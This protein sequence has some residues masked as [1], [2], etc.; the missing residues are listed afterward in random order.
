MQDYIKGEIL[1]ISPHEIRRNKLLNFKAKVSETFGDVDESYSIAKYKGLIFTISNKKS[2]RLFIE[3]SLPKYHFGNN[4][5][6]LTFSDFQ[7][8]IIDLREE[9]G[10]E[11][12]FL[13]L[14][15]I[16]FGVCIDT[17]DIKPTDFLLEEVIS[18]KAIPKELKTHRGKG[19]TVTF[20]QDNY[21]VKFYDKGAQQNLKWNALRY[22]IRAKKM[23][24][25]KELSIKT[26]QDIN[27]KSKWEGLKELLIEVYKDIK[28][29][30]FNSVHKLEN[31][32]LMRYSFGANPQYWSRIWPDSKTYENK[33]KDA[34]YEKAVRNYYRVESTFNAIIEKYGFDKNK[35][36]LLL[37][38]T[39]EIERLINS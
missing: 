18:Y 25:L 23:T 37:K 36:I 2:L 8:V 20:S 27:D 4:Y 21:V 15:N 34:E 12:E 38:I 29:C 16:E 1:N 6:N 33:S 22:E 9:F 32:E 19:C 14:Q 30:R 13:A 31:E 39:N 3:G 11:P 5:Q 35:S 26:L 24:H 17:E 7:Q 10:I 28:I